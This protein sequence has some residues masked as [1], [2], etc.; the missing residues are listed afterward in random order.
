MA[1]CT[2]CGSSIKD[3]ALHC[4]S[5]GAKQPVDRSAMPR[6]DLNAER[7]VSAYSRMESFPPLF[8]TEQPK[9][10]IK[11][12]Q[13]AQG[14]K[15]VSEK[16][17]QGKLRKAILAAALTAIIALGAAA[18]IYLLMPQIKG[19]DEQPAVYLSGY[20]LFVTRDSDKDDSCFVMDLEDSFSELESEEKAMEAAKNLEESIYYDKKEQTLYFTDPSSRLISVKLNRLRPGK[21]ISDRVQVLAESVAP[22]GENEKVVTS[23]YT[24]L[25]EGALYISAEDSSLCLAREGKNRVIA[26]NVDLYA[27]CPGGTYVMYL[28]N[29]AAVSLH[30]QYTMYICSVASGKELIKVDSKVSTVEHIKG[31]FDL[32][33]YTRYDEEN[34]DGPISV[35]V[36]GR[37]IEKE[38][39]LENIYSCENF[40]DEGF[41][42]S[43]ARKETLL[44][45]DYVKDIEE[46]DPDYEQ[47]KTVRDVLKRT[48]ADAKLETVY[49]W[50]ESGAEMIAD[51]V[52]S[53]K[54]L[55]D[56]LLE[57]TV[58]D[59]G[60]IEKLDITELKS[61]YTAVEYLSKAEKLGTLCYSCDKGRVF[62]AN[63]LT[64][65]CMDPEGTEA[66]FID[67]ED[68][69]LY[70]CTPTPDGYGPTVR[71]AGD[72]YGA[73]WWPEA[74]CAVFVRDYNENTGLCD[75][76]VQSDEKISQISYNV[77]LSESVPML[78]VGKTLI[79]MVRSESAVRGQNAGLSIWDGSESKEISKSVSSFAA[80]DSERI[81]Y[82]T[83]TEDE[84]RVLYCTD[85]Q[86]GAIAPDAV[87]VCAPGESSSI[88]LELIGEE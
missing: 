30:R 36:S 83:E 26:E 11:T 75:L 79:Y 76:Y 65:A 86:S 84:G 2:D 40:S 25:E 4:P 29:N 56:N 5:C 1:Y 72:V 74:G 23:G 14:V 32:L 46:T 71:V 60:K 15:T 3:G 80:A 37:K 62:D 88:E 54:V 55:G 47:Y 34:P 6:L 59:Y 61:A 64:F 50:R 35:W 24:V 57:L 78:S 31:E 48:T 19:S 16:K 45:A 17:G 87:F 7:N 38:P 13:T 58:C 66:F 69:S 20:E 52:A 67:L 10:R 73:A 49:F 22:A 8:E 12:E 28:C 82:I 39:V 85:S 44:C 9:K 68:R 42:Y 18:G 70:S 53:W 27:V 41:Y 51:N 81:F 33:W 43:L 77:M 63:G 21:D